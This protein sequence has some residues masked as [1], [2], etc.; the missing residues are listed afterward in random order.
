MRG[1]EGWDKEGGK[2]AVE[3]LGFILF[4][5]AQIMKKGLPQQDRTGVGGGVEGAPKNGTQNKSE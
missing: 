1:G 4:I 2:R 5:F 3:A